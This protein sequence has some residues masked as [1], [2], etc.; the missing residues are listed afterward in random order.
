MWGGVISCSV[1]SLV[2]YPNTWAVVGEVSGPGKLLSGRQGK[3][4]GGL[5][6]SCYTRHIPRG[7]G[8]SLPT[9][10]LAGMLVQHCGAEGLDL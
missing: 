7:R 3:P 9:A 10:G 1:S 4:N 2:V 5:N 6:G 8:S